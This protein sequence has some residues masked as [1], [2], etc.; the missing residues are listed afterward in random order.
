[1]PLSSQGKVLQMSLL[2]HIL[3][4]AMGREWPIP[5]FS[6]NI[7]PIVHM[8]N[9]YLYF[10]GANF[11]RNYAF[12]SHNFM[13][14]YLAKKASFSN[15]FVLLFLLLI[16]PINFAERIQY[17][18]ATACKLSYLEVSPTQIISPLT[19]NSAFHKVSGLRQNIEKFLPQCMT[20]NPIPNTVLIPI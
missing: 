7:F 8:Q 11:M 13:Q 19:L 5:K 12:L 1:L 15:L 6:S 9:T 2:F 16:I 3:K 4:P 18:H 20:S 10:N 17:N 14:A